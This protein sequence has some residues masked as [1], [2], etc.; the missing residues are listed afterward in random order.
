MQLILLKDKSEESKN[1]ETSSVLKVAQLNE[2]KSFSF[3]VITDNADEEIEGD[4]YA[5]WGKALEIMYKALN[6][7]IFEGW[8][9]KI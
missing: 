3:R 2:I 6:K 4:L 8:V 1:W 9:N 7:F 5:N